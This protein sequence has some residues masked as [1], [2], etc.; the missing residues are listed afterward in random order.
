MRVPEIPPHI[1]GAAQILARVGWPFCEVPLSPTPAFRPLLGRPEA[2]ND[3]GE[4]QQPLQR[5]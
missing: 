2:A 1:R 4:P 3:P 5:A